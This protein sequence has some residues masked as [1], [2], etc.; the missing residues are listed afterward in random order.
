MEESFKGPTSSQAGGITLFII[1]IKSRIQMH[2]ILCILLIYCHQ[3]LIGCSCIIGPSDTPSDNI[4]RKWET[5][6]WGIPRRTEAY[7]S[8]SDASLFSSSLPVLHHEKRMCF[9]LI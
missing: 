1:P 6:A 2:V 9:L 4:S 7:H 3:I 5:G 8:S